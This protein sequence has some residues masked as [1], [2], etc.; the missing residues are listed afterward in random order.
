M[1][2]EQKLSGSV[3]DGEQLISRMNAIRDSSERHVVRMH[4]EAE[5]LVDWR[6]HV[7][8]QPLLAV[9]VASAAGFLLMY[10]KGTPSQTAPKQSAPRHGDDKAAR[11]TLTSGAMAFAGTMVGNLVKQTLSNYLKSKLAGVQHDRRENEQPES[12][13]QPAIQSPSRW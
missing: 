13:E 4:A 9:A 6:E 12:Y 1:T 10:R 7:R 11:T 8:A 5:R 2:R 3:T